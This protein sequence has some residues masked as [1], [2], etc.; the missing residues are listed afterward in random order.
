MM[1]FKSF[2]KR[3]NIDFVQGVT[4]VVGPNGSGKSN[5]TDAVRWVL[6]EQSAK[7]LR[8]AK[9]EDIIFSGSDAHK[10][11]NVAEVTLILDN[12]DERLKLPYQEVSVTRRVHRSGESE[13]LLNDQSCRLK[14]ITDLFMDS[15]LGKEAFSII[16]QGRVDEILNSRPQ[17]RR[18]IFE[19]AAGV[20]KY[21]TRKKKAEFKLLEADENL[22]R[23]LD[24]LHELQDRLLPL[25]EQAAKAKDYLHMTNEM[26][27]YDIAV[28]VT[29]AT[30]HLNKMQDA[31][32]AKKE[33]EIKEQA[34][35][36]DITDLEQKIEEANQRLTIIEQQ[37]DAEQQQLVEA[38]AEVERYEGRIALV[39]EQSN[40]RTQQLDKLH[41][42]QTLLHQQLAEQQEAKSTHEQALQQAQ[43]KLAQLKTVITEQQHLLGRT[44]QE[45]AIEIE[46]KK[47]QYIDLLSKEAAL[48]NE[49]KHVEQQLKH[50]HQASTKNTDAYLQMQETLVTV[51]QQEQSAKQ[52]YEQYQ[53]QYKQ[54]KQQETTANSKW[55]EYQIEA[56]KKQNMLFEA[57]Q[58]Q[59]KLKTR[60]DTLAELAADF[61]GYYEGVREILVAREKGQLLVDGAVAELMQVPT[62]YTQAIETALGA[63]TQH[64]ITPDEKEAQKAIHFLKQKRKGRATFLPRSVIKARTIPSSLHQQMKQH[65]AFC[66]IAVETVTY[67]A[68]YD[69]VMHNLLGATIIAAHLQGATEIARMTGFRYRVVT[70]DGDVVNAGGSLTGGAAKRQSNMFSRKAELE[71][72]TQQLTQLS[73]QLIQAEK[74][75]QVATQQ[76]QDTEQQVKE[77]RD[78]LVDVEQHLQ[79]AQ[80]YF[81]QCQNKRIQLETQTNYSQ[82]EQQ[83]AEQLSHSFQSQHQQALAELKTL[84]ESLT[85][86][87]DT[88][89]HLEIMKQ[90]GESEREIL[91][92]QLS[93]NK[94]QLAVAQEQR[95]MHSTRIVELTAEI[96]KTINQLQ[97]ISEEITLFE[98]QDSSITHE[99]VVEQLSLWRVKRT[100][101]KEQV[102]ILQKERTHQQ[103][104]IQTDHEQVQKLRLQHK[105]YTTQI[106]AY[107][108]TIEKSQAQIQYVEEQLWDQYEWDLRAESEVPVLT[109]PIEQARRH[110][111]LL[112]QSI[113][114][115]GNVNLDAIEEYEQVKERH[116][117]LEAQRNDLLEAQ[118]TLNEAIREMDDE[119]TTRF[120]TT[121]E[122]VR[123]HFQ[124]AFQEL[125]GGGKA[126]LVLVDPTNILETGIDIVAQPPGKKLQNLSLLSGGERA[127]VAIAILFAI[128]RTRPVPF[129]VLDEVEA[130]LDEANVSRYT[131]YLRKL[132]QETQFIVITHRKGTMEGA[133]VL[134]GITMQESGVSKLVSVKLED[135]ERA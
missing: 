28:L 122:A 117:F 3:T 81:Q 45:I 17:D 135:E 25:E 131:Q 112:K 133:D 95:Q 82:N 110:V 54:L 65:E 7:S 64:I 116:T 39:T 90:K 121:F 86:L 43:Q 6:G 113:E 29:D 20:L 77:V 63:A 67:D 24:I 128:L 4:A 66:S 115:L 12:T 129:C 41:Q 70:L 37:L 74:N 76:A 5:V 21:K 132:S 1:G 100:D 107:T 98:Q 84:Q 71:T 52:Q 75:V 123:I 91:Q 58:H 96:D 94:A 106:H 38:S 102:A 101:T 46:D 85:T 118:Q 79:S 99:E 134:Y 60:K 48:K 51:Q 36:F 35:A 88:I 105:N 119:M 109:M 120:S 13:Y 93:E 114:E 103:Q 97:I 53:M 57:Y 42:E 50:H 89:D 83:D 9:M 130:A 56:T 127:L 19:E 61:S 55:Q 22:L 31:T 68:M 26:K 126:D 108:L 16:S 15:G 62:K 73:S 80:H 69:T 2:A 27:D 87:S 33:W 14:D 78:A 10:S 8:G 47:S 34:L 124:Q 11:V 18:A 59:H 104:N 111:K 44:A 92:Q 23:I 30:A 49:V 125:F 40:N 72:L 32:K